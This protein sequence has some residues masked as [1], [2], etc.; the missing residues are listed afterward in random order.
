MPHITT[1]GEFI[2]QSQTRFPESKGELSSLISS[3]RLA[4]KI[5]NAEINK[6]G[7][8][9]EIMGRAG[10]TNIQGEEQ[11]KLDVYANRKFIDAIEAR[12]QVCGI[13]SE[14]EDSFIAFES[15]QCRNGKYVILIDP[16]DGSSNIDVN[17]SVGTI[18]SIYR[19]ISPVGTI[20]TEEDFLQPGNKQV[21]AG[22]FVYGSSTMMVYTTG[23]G[24]NGFTFDPTIGVFFLSHPNFKIPAK[25]NIY[26]VNEGNYPYFEQNVRDYLKHIKE[27]D[28][29]SGR[30]YSS[31]YIGSM[32]SDIHRNM[33]KGGLY[34][35]PGT[36][37]KP[38]GKLR[39]CYE[40]NPMAF[41]I[42]QAGGKATDG[43][44]RIMDIKPTE[45]HQRAPLYLGSVDMVE[46]VHSFINK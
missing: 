43:H 1:V 20:A 18:F 30:P 28:A 34:M 6:A 25:G 22:Y 21:A 15:E 33:I 46:E 16:L 32:V 31:R 2:V 29:I 26:S 45:L 39:L 24:V 11:Q 13:A 38:Q 23:N 5:V 44:Q 19:R 36:S 12:Q 9:D 27:E 17:V 14:E 40:C 8:V 4:A 42:E 37:R 35:Y 3:L 7:L 10:D 41:I